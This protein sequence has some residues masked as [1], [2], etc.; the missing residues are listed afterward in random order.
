MITN[1]S[2]WV[3]F[4]GLNSLR[5]YSQ[6]DIDSFAHRLFDHQD[7]EKLLIDYC[8]IQDYITLLEGIKKNI[9]PTIQQIVL[10]QPKSF[11][12]GGY[13]FTYFS[14]S[15]YKYEDC[16]MWRKAN[17]SVR[18]E[19]EYQKQ[20]EAT[21]KVGGRIDGVEIEKVAVDIIDNFKVTKIINSEGG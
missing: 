6:D 21:C 4:E 12:I 13:K 2:P 11:E 19:Q 20:I 1:L 14:Q 10:N 17:E 16:E 15:K 8:T 3:A 5:N 7:Q 9:R 18:L